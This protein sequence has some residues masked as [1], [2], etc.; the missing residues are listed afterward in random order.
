MT[1]RQKERLGIYQQVI[2]NC[3]ENLMIVSL[4]ENLR[5]FLHGFRSAVAA[6]IC[7]DYLAGCHKED[8]IPVADEF[9][10]FLL[11]FAEATGQ[12]LL[13]FAEDTGNH[14]LYQKTTYALSHLQVQSQEIRSAS[15]VTI[16]ET[17]NEWMPS[18]ESYGMNDCILTS[19]N[20]SIENYMG[21]ASP[22]SP[23]LPEPEAYQDCFRN[24]LH[25]ANLLLKDRIDGLMEEISAQHYRFYQSYRRLRTYGDIN[26]LL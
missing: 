19:L 8:Q 14:L 10:N 3:N 5:R 26:Y 1:P 2:K 11:P 17:L 9:Y 23:V 16:A 4:S 12:G 7:I 6:I 21:I 18:L 24:I 15:F 22:L 13:D 25:T 20:I